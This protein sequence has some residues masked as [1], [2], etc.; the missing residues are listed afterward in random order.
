MFA[1]AAVDRLGGAAALC[2]QR[3]VT[4]RATLRRAK[5]A[6]V[7]ARA[8]PEE[9]TV[10]VGANLTPGDQLKTTG[11]AVEIQRQPT[12]RADRVILVNGSAA[13][14]AQR[15]STRHAHPIF[16][17]NTA[18]ASGTPA[19]VSRRGRGCFG[20]L[21]LAGLNLNSSNRVGELRAAPWTLT[22]TSANPGPTLGTVEHERKTAGRATVRLTGQGTAT[23]KTT[24]AAASRTLDLAPVHLRAT[25]G[26]RDRHGFLRVI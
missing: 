13:A 19:T 25:V 16:D 4:S 9:N 18:A 23:V 15:L 8:T 17:V 12:R 6:R 5:D 1:D 3:R 14:W 10:T 22:R 2:R 24:H 21:T 7:T 11:R 20:F 26:T